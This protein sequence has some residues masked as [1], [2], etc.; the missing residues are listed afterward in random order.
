MAERLGRTVGEI[1]A[2]MSY[3]ELLEWG[4]YDDIRAIEAQHNATHAKTMGGR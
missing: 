2:Q 1:E 4:V 3:R